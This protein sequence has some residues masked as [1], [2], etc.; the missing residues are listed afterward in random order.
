MASIKSLEKVSLITCSD[1]VLFLFK[2]TLS[3]VQPILNVDTEG[4]SP[5]IWQ[6]RL[7]FDRLHQ[8]EVRNQLKPQDLKQ[9]AASFFEDYLAIGP[10][11]SKDTSS[12]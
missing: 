8:D 10:I 11:T 9:N 4:V 5:M 2:R 1:E 3:N 7:T 6:N 12:K